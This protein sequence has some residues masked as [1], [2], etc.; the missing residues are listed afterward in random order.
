MLMLCSISLNSSSLEAGR[1]TDPL[2]KCCLQ[3]G[4]EFMFEFWVLLTKLP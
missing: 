2:P 4:L 3:N 1:T